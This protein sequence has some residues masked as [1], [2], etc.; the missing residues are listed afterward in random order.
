MGGATGPLLLAV[1]LWGA[2]AAGPDYGD[3]AWQ[4]QVL[5]Q[6]R[7]FELHAA[8]EELRV[9]LGVCPSKHDSVLTRCEG[10]R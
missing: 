2:L 5:A 4:R 8:E 9:G 7:A 3:E 6:A 1:G 10:C